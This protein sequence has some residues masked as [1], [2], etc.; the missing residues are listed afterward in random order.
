[1]NVVVL[2]IVIVVASIAGG[3]AAQHN[4]KNPD[5][6]PRIEIVSEGK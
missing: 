4:D 1:M 6:S 3:T 2:F 5:P